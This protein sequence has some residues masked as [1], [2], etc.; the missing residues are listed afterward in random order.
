VL[1]QY[2]FAYPL[3]CGERML[4]AV[5]MYHV[6]G[7]LW[8]GFASSCGA[9]LHVMTDFDAAETVRALDEE[10]IAFTFLVPRVIRSCLSNVAAVSP[11]QDGAL[12]TIGYGASPIDAGTLRRAMEVFRCEFVQAFGMTEAPNLTNLTDRDHRQ[13]LASRPEL[14]LSCGRPG[15]GSEIKIVD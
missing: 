12:R 8:T 11:R 14:F 10:H 9:R 2:R 4:V 13:A 15:P 7:L 3:G 5:P 6:G 1:M